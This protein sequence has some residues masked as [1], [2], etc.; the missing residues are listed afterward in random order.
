MT[1]Q[2]NWIE[3][4]RGLCTEDDMERL[5][6]MEMWAETVTREYHIELGHVEEFEEC[7]DYMCRGWR[8]LIN[9]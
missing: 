7:A 4:F 9:D 1:S 8:K 2:D 5:E 6:E 3:R